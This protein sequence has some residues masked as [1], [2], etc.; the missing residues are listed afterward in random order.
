LQAIEPCQPII[1]TVPTSAETGMD[2]DSVAALLQRQPPPAF[3]YAISDGHNPLGISLSQEKRQQLVE[4]ARRYH[5]PIIEDDAYGLLWYD[6]VATPPM[7]ALDEDWVCYLGSFSKI[8]APALRVGWLLVPESLMASLAILKE[9]SDINTATLTQR[10]IAA[11]LEMDHLTHHL[12]QLR[13]TYQARRDTMVR[14]LRSFFPPGTRWYTP[15][16]GMFIWVELPMDV[17]TAVLLKTAI[18]KEGIAF[19]P[20]HA[21]GINGD[22]SAAHCMRLNFSHCSVVE[23]EEGIKRLARLL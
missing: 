19:L 6:H 4:L 21:F 16:N 8:L 20:G 18:E 10:A 5:V 17:D 22:R 23:I 7:R 13:Q 15:N 12:V 3:I 11:Y 9:A 14:M 1:L 2:V